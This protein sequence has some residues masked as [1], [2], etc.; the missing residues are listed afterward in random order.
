MWCVGFGVW[1]VGWGCGAW[2]GG[3]ARGL[4]DLWCVSSGVVA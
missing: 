3:V 4:Q 2:A 1:R